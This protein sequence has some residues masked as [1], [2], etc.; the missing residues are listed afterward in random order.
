MRDNFKQIQILAQLG[1]TRIGCSSNI[2]IYYE[3]DVFEE[4]CYDQKEFMNEVFWGCEDLHSIQHIIDDRYKDD[5][6]INI[7]AI[8]HITNE[9]L[10]YLD[11]IGTK[12]LYINDENL[13][14]PTIESLRNNN[15]KLDYQYLGLI[16]KF[17]YNQNELTPYVNIKRL[18]PG[19]MY[20]GYIWKLWSEITAIRLF[21]TVNTEF[22]LPLY[23]QESVEN[24]LKSIEDKTIWV[25]LSWGLDSSL[26]SALVLQANK[27]LEKPKKIRFFTTENEE[28][29]EYAQKVA[30]HLWIKLELISGDDVELTEEEMYYVNETPVDLGSVIPNMKLFKRIASMWIKTVITWDGPDELFRWYKRNAEDFDYHMHDIHNELVFYH[31]PKLEKASR[32]YWIHLITPYITPQIWNMAQAFDVKIYK[33]NV[34]DVAR[35]LIPDEVIDRVKQP[36]K[37]KDLRQDIIWYQHKFLANFISYAQKTWEST[38]TT[39]KSS[40]R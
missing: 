38:P 15:S 17:G 40:L 20:K 9:V 12:S 6:F 24:R 13:I 36:L 5:I 10:I 26:I 28:D 22:M 35:W 39:K 33:G 29:Y 23:L 21:P 34:K 25:L 4:R 7:I 1:Y 14:S 31:F 27:D 2:E 32:Y 8:D 11:P 19:F 18:L 30:K 3:W 16:R 37:N